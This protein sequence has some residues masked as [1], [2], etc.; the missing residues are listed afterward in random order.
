MVMCV[1]CLLLLLA[2]VSGVHGDVPDTWEANGVQ[3]SLAALKQEQYSSQIPSV[4]GSSL[5][6]RELC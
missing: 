6:L 5:R 4:P 1:P 2:A 3:Y